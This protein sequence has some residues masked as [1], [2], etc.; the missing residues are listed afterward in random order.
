MIQ[1]SKNRI[2][3]LIVRS[4]SGACFLRICMYIPWVKKQFF[5]K[6]FGQMHRTSSC[7]NEC[8]YSTNQRNYD[9]QHYLSAQ[10][11]YGCT[12]HCLV[13]VYFTCVFSNHA[14]LIFCP[15]DLFINIELCEAGIQE[16]IFLFTPT[17]FIKLI[18]SRI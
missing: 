18:L 12:N 5:F 2:Q 3:K 11:S 9:L 14:T 15:L 16:T 6:L 13:V 17:I 7:T 10:D 4:I 8:V 1:D